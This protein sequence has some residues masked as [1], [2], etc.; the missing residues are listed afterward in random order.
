MTNIKDVA[1]E[2]GVSVAT[3][4][5]VFSGSQPVSDGARERVR[6]VAL[7]LGYRPNA[8]ARSLRMEQTNTLGLVIPSIANPFFTAIARAVEDAAWGEGY[9]LILGNTD[10]NP[11]KEARY[12]ELLMQ[13]RV[14]GLI[15]SPARAWSPYLKEVIEEVPVVFLD[16]VASGIEAPV[17]RADGRRA[18]GSLVSYLVGLGHERLGI[19]SGPDDTVSG[20]ERLET[21]LREAETLGFPVAGERVRAGDFKRG[22]GGVAMR[23]LL[24]LDEPPTAVFAANNSMALGALA[25]LRASGVSVP[26]ETSFAS[27]DDVGWFEL[28]SPPVTAIAQPIQSLGEAAARTLTGILARMHSEGYLPGV[29]ARNR[30]PGAGHTEDAI[31]EAELIIRGS[32][33][34]PAGKPA[35]PRPRPGPG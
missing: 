30:F 4:S 23:E 17:V 35:I 16:R 21:F 13:K 10:E 18:V 29:N 26:D 9:S 14:D 22:S 24:A 32:C 19:I 6:E 25:E 33:G 34:P 11:E 5:R 28:L 12:L 27:F 7:R 15:I 3:V 1:R 20:N 2:A 8:V 31:M